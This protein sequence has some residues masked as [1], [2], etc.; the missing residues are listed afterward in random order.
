VLPSNEFPL[1]PRVNYAPKPP[2]PSSIRSTIINSS[3]VDL[4]PS[5]IHILNKGFN[6]SLVPHHTRSEDILCSIESITYHLS[7]HE[8][9]Q[10]RQECSR[11]LR[12][13]KLPKPNLSKEEFQS[14]CNLNDNPN[15]II[16]KFDKGNAIL[17]MNTSNY[18]PRMHN[19]LYS[20]SYKPLSKNPINIIT[21]LVTKAIKSSSLD[22]S[23]QKHL[24]YR[25][26]QTPRI[27]GQPKIHKKD[28]P[29]RPMVSIID[30]PTYALAHFLA[31]KLRTFIGKTP[32][33]IKDP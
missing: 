4:N 5:F 26:P 14:I 6:F 15:I 31:N 16:L 8:A 19:L 17:V 30:A 11:I 27:H 28:I 7:T 33:F 21:N 13:S 12:L 29:L 1:C 9:E 20:F 2:S 10:I 24:I 22:P 25:N 32:S 3:L 18:E 23:V